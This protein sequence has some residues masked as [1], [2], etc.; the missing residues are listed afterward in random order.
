MNN[1]QGGVIKVI[2][3]GVILVALVAGYYY[4]LTNMRKPKGVD[5]TETA[6]A[7]EEVLLRNLDKNYPPS[8]KEVVKY[9]GEITKCFYNEEYTEEEFKE[10]ALQIQRLY[11]DEL[12]ANQTQQQYL[13]SLKLDVKNFKDQGTVISSVPPASSVD[14]ETFSKNGFE[15]AELNCTISLRTGTELSR[16]EEVFLLRKDGDGHWK[17]YG[18][19]LARDNG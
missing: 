5:E 4:Y 7:V 15:W 1:K 19:A 18:F 2:V 16:T 8:A 12:I 14:V 9:Y 11:D 17:I 6:S 10:L 3:V 13:D